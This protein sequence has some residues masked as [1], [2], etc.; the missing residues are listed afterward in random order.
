MD[1]VAEGLRRSTGKRTVSRRQALFLGGA[2]LGTAIFTS[3]VLGSLIPDDEQPPS[4]KPILF[5]SPSPSLAVTDAAPTEAVAPKAKATVRVAAVTPTP[6]LPLVP[7]AQAKDVFARCSGAEVAS[8]QKMIQKELPIFTKDKD[9]NKRVLGYRTIIAKA[10]KEQNFKSDSVIPQALLGLI[11]VESEGKPDVRPPQPAP[12]AAPIPESEWATGLCQVKPSTAEM[13]AQKLGMST[14]PNLFDPKVN[15]K[16]ALEYLD[17]LKKK[18]SD[19][20]L[21]LWA[22][23]LGEG[24]M[25][26]AI[27]TYVTRNLKI[28]LP[29]GVKLSTTGPTSTKELVDKYNLNFVKLI[30]SG[31]VVGRLMQKDAFNDNT[32]LYVPRIGA[33]LVALSQT[34]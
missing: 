7:I 31:Q 17:Y 23:H 21:T 9:A 12:P 24:N 10:A 8:V 22:Y 2:T 1:R 5:P 33:A 29:Q 15:I 27:E 30:N 32:H 6:E 16:I 3:T 28:S 34:V 26:K 20:S 13:F 19:V 14:Q 4:K 11:R 25:T 18:F